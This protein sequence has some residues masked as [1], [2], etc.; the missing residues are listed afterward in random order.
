[1]KEML[2]R[3]LSWLQFNNRVLQEAQDKNVPL[4]QR[5]RFLG[6]FSN[7]QDE[8]IKVRVADLIRYS[9]LKMNNLPTVSGGYT[10]SD[11]LHLVNQQLQKSHEIFCQTYDEI[12]SEMKNHQIFVVNETMLSASQQDFCLNYFLSVIS[13]RLVPL[14]LR[15]SV[16]YHFYLMIKFIWL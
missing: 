6:I 14:M 15:K 8:F 3:E 5:L 11:L 7:N 16:K 13:V 1:M 2:N 10:Y 12:I 4:I 9:E